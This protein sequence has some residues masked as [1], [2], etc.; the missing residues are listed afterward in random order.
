VTEGASGT[1]PTTAHPTD[2][3]IVNAVVSMRHHLAAN[4][5]PMD[6]QVRAAPYLSGP[7]SLERVAESLTRGDWA[8]ARWLAARLTTHDA[9]RTDGIGALLSHDPV[10][11]DHAARLG[12]VLMDEIADGVSTSDLPEFF[13]TTMFR[14]RTAAAAAIAH[15]LLSAGVDERSDVVR[16]A[17]T[18]V[19]DEHLR[20]RATR[21]LLAAAGPDDFRMLYPLV[22]ESD[23]DH[24]AI[25]A[26]LLGMRP[27]DAALTPGQRELLL[28]HLNRPGWYP[29]EHQLL[30]TFRHM[31]ET[32]RTA[33]EFAA[34]PLQDPRDLLRVFL[35]GTVLGCIES[36]MG[37]AAAVVGLSRLLH[38]QDDK[39]IGQCIFE[40]VRVWDWQLAHRVLEVARWPA[41]P[42]GADRADQFHLMITPALRLLAGR[43]D[44]GDL[45]RLVALGDACLRAAT[46]TPGEYTRDY[47][48]Y[49]S[50]IVVT[51]RDDVD[52]IG[53]MAA[54]EAVTKAIWGADDTDA[55]KFGSAQDDAEVVE[56]HGRYVLSG[57]D[58]RQLAVHSSLVR[59]RGPGALLVLIDVIIETG[60]LAHARELLDAVG[61]VYPRNCMVLLWRHKLA[62]HTWNQALAAAVLAQL[63]DLWRADADDAT[64]LAQVHVLRDLV[65]DP[66]A[67]HFVKER[68]GRVALR[69]AFRTW[70]DELRGMADG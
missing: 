42:I 3:A 22:T 35:D 44:R 12:D 15:T 18:A 20:T 10:L 11:D 65:T 19:S 58:V 16:A 37:R 54:M 56:Y 70:A 4:S 69:P 60:D 40:S 6:A 25:R 1:S 66:Q 36:D 17:A 62:T 21:D 57:Q 55:L 2:Q 24:D 28:W 51:Q 64:P 49:R 34:L 50:A 27:D 7:D 53:E 5:P 52:S 31:V 45:A 63:R 38:E 39:M 68:A 67:A 13:M 23:V 59:R 8:Q 32:A 33:G 41:G 9:V 61:E 46:G 48:A 14:S 47:V 26:A 43:S 30:D 29:D